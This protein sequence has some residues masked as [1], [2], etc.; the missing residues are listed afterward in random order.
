MCD[1]ATHRTL[2]AKTEAQQSP[3]NS[4]KTPMMVETCSG[5]CGFT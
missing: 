1:G 3:Q 5:Q 2:E 4:F